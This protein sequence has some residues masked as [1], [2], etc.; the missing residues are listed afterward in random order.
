MHQGDFKKW[1]R[2]A[3]DWGADYRDTLRERPV[4]PKMQ[5]GEIAARIAASA[6]E[7]PEPM[8][9]IFA[10]FERD[11][12][13]G[14]TH[15]QHPRFFAYFPANAA[16][17]SVVAEYLV[18]AMAAQCMLWQTSP[19]AT[20]LETRVIDWLRQAL[21]LPDGFSGVI[22]DSASSATLSAVLV[23]RER[24]LDW[25]GNRSGLSGQPKLRIY[26][27]R[28]GA[29][30]DR[31]RHLGVRH[32]RGESRARAD[33]WTVAI[34]G[35]RKRSRLPSRRTAP[36]AFCRRASSHASA[37]QASEAPTTSRP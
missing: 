7:A 12:V 1:S 6:P 26:C 22:Q 8:D 27:I 25:A 31:P 16:P 2:R 36:R 23:M 33:R 30:L 15:W 18:S 28:S 13:P 9:E 34:D 37:A 24:A 17:A 35:C 29:H 14:M 20:E 3:A 19:A 11:I 4:R 10:D 5:P 21:G 32:R